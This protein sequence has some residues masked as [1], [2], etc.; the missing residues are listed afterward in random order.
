MKL[1]S[2]SVHANSYVLGAYENEF[3]AKKPEKNVQK[4][5]FCFFLRVLQLL[6]DFQFGSRQFHWFLPRNEKKEVG[7]TI[8][9]VS[10]RY[11]LNSGNT[12]SRN[13][14]KL[15]LVIPNS[16]L[17]EFGDPQATRTTFE[18]LCKAFNCY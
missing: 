13:F 3:E 14:K 6:T 2:M 7:E 18:D 1:L 11:Q 15:R 12:D 16:G 4:N 8:Y 9:G 10:D 5:Q 17:P